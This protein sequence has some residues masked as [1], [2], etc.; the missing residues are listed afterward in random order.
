[1][2]AMVWTRQPP[3]RPGYYL[4]RESFCENP[5]LLEVAS[6]RG[7][8]QTVFPGQAGPLPLDSYPGEWSPSGAPPFDPPVS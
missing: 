4:Y 5:V 2:A 6:L 8:L 1:M 7:Q 3:R